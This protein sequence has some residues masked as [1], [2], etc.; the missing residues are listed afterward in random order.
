MLAE[1]AH[2]ALSGYAEDRHPIQTR[3]VG[4]M[5]EV[6]N[7]IS[8]RLCDKAETERK[9]KV[10]LE[11]EVGNE[12]AQ[13]Q[14]VTDE[15]AAAKE[16]VAAKAEELRTLKATLAECEQA[17][18]LL[19]SDEVSVN[20]RR[21]QLNKE[22]GKFT[23]VKDNLQVLIDDGISAGGSAKAAKALLN[24]FLKQITA[25]GAEP[26]L[27]AAAPPVLLRKPEE[28]EGFDTC[29][30][31]SLQNILAERLDGVQKSLDEIAAQVEQKLPEKTAKAEATAKAKAA[32]DDAKSQ[33]D[34]VEEAA[35]DKEVA[36]VKATTKA[37]EI[38]KDIEAKAIA[39]EAANAETNA[40]A[41]VLAIFKEVAERCA[42][43]PAEKV[44]PA[45]ELEAKEQPGVS[46]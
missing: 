5:K 45:A 38:E 6:L 13:V 10:L 17:E 33:L 2:A 26:A 46:A 43:E 29:V 20:R 42:A 44:E 19:A 11:A 28:R 4:F 15:V 1:G 34:A 39:I 31:E 3:M 18:A 37:E 27:L 25:L 40:F 16:V 22:K 14:I 8:T 36:L 30:M 7:D 35:S 24:K 9:E 32:L 23:D 21:D 12:K 41:E